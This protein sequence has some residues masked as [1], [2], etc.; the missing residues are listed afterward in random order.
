MA[1][2]NLDANPSAFL[3]QRLGQTLGHTLSCG[4]LLHDV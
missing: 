2:V 1:R 3:T 4:Y